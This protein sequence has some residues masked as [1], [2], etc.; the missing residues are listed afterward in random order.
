MKYDAFSFEPVSF[1]HQK[2]ISLFK[3]DILTLDEAAQKKAQGQHHRVFGTLYHSTWSIFKEQALTLFN[4][5]NFCLA[6]LV[7]FV[8][9]NQPRYLTNLTFMLVVVIN[10]LFGI[11][12]S[13]KAKKTLENIRRKHQ[14][15]AYI[16]RKKDK[17]V[18]VSALLPEEE[19]V[20]GDVLFLEAGKVLSVD[21]ILLQAED[22]EVDESA[23][24][25]ESDAIYKEKGKRVFSGSSILSGIGY[26][27][28]LAVG[29][30]VYAHTLSTTLQEKGRVKSQIMESIN[31]L[32]KA[33]SL[34]LLPMGLL[35][36]FSAFL[37][38]G[39]NT[40]DLDRLS[41]VILSVVA[42]LVGMI[43]EGLV[44]LT[45]LAFVVSVTQLAL[46]RNTLVQTLPAV[47][48]LARVDVLCLDKT[49]TLTTGA[50]QVLTVLPQSPAFSQDGQ[51]LS[52]LLLHCAQHSENQTQKALKRFFEAQYQA[53][54]PDASL[55]TIQQKSEQAGLQV[56]E[57]ERFHSEKKYASTTFL[58]E[59]IQERLYLG[60]PD[61]LLEEN[62]LQCFFSKYAPY[63]QEGKRVLVLARSIL[64]E[65]GVFETQK[66]V[67][68]FFILE[69]LLRAN[70]LET[71]AYFKQEQVEPF[72]L[73][74]DHTQTVFALAKQIGLPFEWEDVVDLSLYPQEEMDLQSESVKQIFQ[75]LVQSKRIFGRVS[76]LQKKYLVQ[77]LQALGHT[78]AMTGDGQNDVLALKA[79]DC[80]IAMESGSEMARAAADVV[81]LSNDLGA[82]VPVLKE[83]RKVIHNL[84]RV[85]S[86]FL[87]KTFYSCCLAL[88]F[89]FLPYRYPFLPIQLTL[90]SSL[91]IGIP[92][93]VLALSPNTALVQGLFL[94]KVLKKAVPYGLG[95]S[96]AVIIH[97]FLS[98]I[99][100]RFAPWSYSQTFIQEW[101]V[102]LTA[103]GA[104]TLLY[105]VCFP[106][107]LT[108]KILYVF[109]VSAFTSAVFLF[110]QFF[111]FQTFPFISSKV[112][113]IYLFITGLGMP[114]FCVALKKRIQPYLNGFLSS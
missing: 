76:P 65:Q 112:L 67:L 114:F 15:Q 24:T 50:M 83:G 37:K 54:Y 58:K 13:V 102:L 63:L 74:G 52:Q 104:F 6:A 77:A 28:V 31:R 5:L 98:A 96:L 60:A 86:L 26:V 105:E 78:V 85:A 32:V 48:S 1:L 110:P 51:W 68:A 92:A 66:E 109:C 16:L 19:I 10:T 99:F 12:Q 34:L 84:E 88:A 40:M 44:L 81:L 57:K 56:L 46:K 29:E 2:Q 17:D 20:V 59:G 35:L 111:L 27:K 41:L 69:D 97:H 9:F 70:A 103:L 7:L 64:N 87:T 93:F 55:R 47:E 53:L 82:L 45:T 25:G 73:S 49:G 101:S 4:F 3:E 11:L 33:L 91:T 62:Q 42:A 21:G 106:W 30:Q 43:P 108:R 39:L 36:F 80:A 61:F 100:F 95:I 113:W 75:A 72:I 94:Q 18:F 23:L 79:A 14:N 90:M 8:S 22:L 107:N 89:I 71:L 38:L